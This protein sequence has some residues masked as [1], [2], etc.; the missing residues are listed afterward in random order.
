MEP[1]LVIRRS[2]LT[3][4]QWCRSVLRALR[5]SGRVGSIQLGPGRRTAI[6]PLPMSRMRRCRPGDRRVIARTS[7]ARSADLLEE[8][9]AESRRVQD[10]CALSIIEHSPKSDGHT[11][12]NSRTT[13]RDGSDIDLIAGEILRPTR[14]SARPNP[15]RDF[16]GPFGRS[17]AGSAG[18]MPRFLR[19]LYEIPAH[20]LPRPRRLER[21]IVA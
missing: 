8:A 19:A 1:A 2:P 20:G 10:W 21:L 11:S 17:A 15:S 13:I 4:C 5:I 12:G 3:A 6:S 9:E 18:R 14:P 16:A 7:F